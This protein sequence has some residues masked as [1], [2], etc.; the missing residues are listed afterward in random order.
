MVLFPRIFAGIILAA[1]F[2]AIMSTVSSM[3]LVSAS[4]IV[5]D[6]W[7]DALG[8][9]L[10]LTARAQ[11]DRLVTLVLGLIVL[12]MALV[13][14]PFLQA[15]V[16]YAIGGLASCFLAP[17]VFGLY[18]Q[19]ATTPGAIASIATGTGSYILIS[20][21]F[22]RT[23]GVHDVTWSIGAAVTAMVSVSLLTE[24]PSRKVIEDFWGITTDKRP[25]SGSYQ[26]DGSPPGPRATIA[27]GGVE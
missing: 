25:D 5:G 26:G 9:N 4:G 20:T 6:V 10:S 27:A 16:F 13:P 7:V 17:L 21:Y 14:P 11:M 3:L 2:A 22:P 15:I 8:K 24:K 1:P 12:L 18:W 23:F 19:R